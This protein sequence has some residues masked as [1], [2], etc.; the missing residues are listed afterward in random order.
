MV[1]KTDKIQGQV[2]GRVL[3]ELL[4]TFGT[5]FGTFLDIVMFNFGGNVK[6]AHM[7][8]SKTLSSENLVL[9]MSKGTKLAQKHLQ[10]LSGTV[11]GFRSRV[12]NIFEHF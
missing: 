12:R 5:H 7:P 10:D 6:R 8:F 2:L 9:R 11:P 4:I 1:P 3:D